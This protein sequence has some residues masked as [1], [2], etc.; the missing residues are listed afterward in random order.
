LYGD[1][2]SMNISEDIEDVFAVFGS[3]CQ[4]VSNGTP[5]EM[6]FAESMV[7]VRK[8]MSTAMLTGA[9]HL[10]TNSW[11]CADKYAVYLHDFL[12]SKTRGGTLSVCP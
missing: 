10:P 9:P 11:A 12:P 5:Q 2:F 8:R 7:R 3:V 6:A 1:T 4:P